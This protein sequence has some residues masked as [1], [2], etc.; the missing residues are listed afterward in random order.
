MALP[1]ATPEDVERWYSER[2]AIDQTLAE[3]FPGFEAEHEMEHF[4]DDVAIRA[5]DSGYRDYQHGLMSH[6]VRRLR[7]G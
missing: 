5:R 7:G 3:K 2:W 4:F 1:L 6:Y